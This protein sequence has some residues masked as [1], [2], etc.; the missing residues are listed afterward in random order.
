[1]NNEENNIIQLDT[2]PTGSKCVI[3]KVNG[4]GGLRHRLIEMGFVKGEVVTVMKN[5]PL[6]DP[7]EYKV[8]SSHVSLRRE[9]AQKIQVVALGNGNA[10]TEP[11]NGVIEEDAINVFN[12]KSKEISVALVGNPNCGKTSF[13]NH[14]TGLHEK[15]GN[16]SGVTV[17][18]K[19]GEF[20][21][22]GYT[23]NLIDLP[24]TYS[25]TEYTPEELYVREFITKQNP[26]IVLNIVDA[27]NL[28]RNLYLTTQLIDMNVRMVMA[29][30]MYDELNDR[31]D[32]FDYKSLSEMLG[33]PIIPTTAS[34]GTG[35]SEVLQTIINVYEN[36]AKLTR[37][38]HVNYGLDIE[39]QISKVKQL[40]SSTDN[41]LTSHTPARS[42][43]INLIEG[44]KITTE[45]IEA[46]PDGKKIIETAEKCRKE[47]ESRYND[48][49]STTIVNA[50]YAF[51]R[52]A[53]KETYEPNPDNSKAERPYS[54]DR[55][56]TH[57]W[58]GFP[59]LL[60]F[61]W[62]MFQ[63]TFT[64]GEPL[65]NWIEQGVGWLGGIIG[66]SM[67]DGILKDLIVDGI[68]AGV[69]G[70]IVFL[71]NILILFM[72]IS[73]LEDTGY[74]ARAAFII[75]K[76]MHR[77]GLHGKSFIPFLIG[78]GCGVPAIM[79]TRTLENK[80]DRILTIIGIPF[81]SCSARLPVYL[82]LV[83]AFFGK[84]QGLILL[85]LYLIGIVVAVLTALLLKNTVFKNN[86]EHFVMELPPYR[87]PTLR[88]TLIHMWDK[89]V[90]YLKKM[91]TV[92]LA[93]S[94]IIWA[95]G[96]FPRHSA[97]SDAIAQRIAQ[98]ESNN[99]MSNEEKAETIST[100]TLQEKA[101]QSE[102]SYIGRLGRFVA[103]VVAPLGF[104]WKMGVSL[105]TGMGAKEI[106]VSTM[107]VLYQADDN[108]DENS[109]AL[110]DKLKE[111]RW[112]SGQRAGQ[113]VFTPLVAY[114]YML[115]ILLYFP[116][117]AAIAAIRREAG[118]GWM[119]FSVV[120]NT[121]IAW[122][123]C[124]AVYQIGMLF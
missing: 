50:R 123:V 60:L 48:D 25:I 97:E 113:P 43:A 34:K 67:S 30:N 28:E 122:I 7:V 64:L 9:E 88:N 57:R 47:L 12:R 16:Y 72:F 105:I 21:H 69:G 22:N 120:Y 115:F 10:D 68:I 110:I 59:V 119:W 73:I 31:G 116:C 38:I 99:T 18:M 91:G 4:Y 51:I 117:I 11:Y 23:L 24:G 17:D 118:R 86:S 90:Q 112:T 14:A 75:D 26:D 66:D 41:T 84:N 104:D 107:G 101:A 71:P 106:V 80:K 62:I 83:G 103:P 3:V 93:A 82:L 102:N 32:K 35:I 111:Q 78:F 37:H 114:V 20:H 46:L 2:M 70:V 98:V 6:L 92:I 108:A 36:E 87:I 85:S 40:I 96:Y 58:L 29:L 100:L 8:M 1:M 109:T 124:F 44:N 39:D 54:I 52:G 27:S 19:V 121:L 74:M 76:L 42:I 15:V 77:I 95:L 79:A 61:L 56:L 81:M 5:A 45:E 55:I 13:F 49:A 94:V 65:Q 63:A 33:F 53:L 89:S